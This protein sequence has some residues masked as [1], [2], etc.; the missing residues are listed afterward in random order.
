MTIDKNKEIM[1]QGLSELSRAFYDH[2]TSAAGGIFKDMM[3]LAGGDFDNMLKAQVFLNNQMSSIYEQAI[4]VELSLYKAGLEAEQ[5][6]SDDF[7]CDI[8]AADD[9]DEDLMH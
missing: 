1:M 4:R 9:E 8:C 6:G 7:E 5:A 3:A 2:H